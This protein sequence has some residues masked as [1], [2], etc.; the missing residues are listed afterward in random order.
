MSV[1]HPRQRSND[2]D[3]DDLLRKLRITVSS[4]SVMSISIELAY[5]R[6]SSFLFHASSTLSSRFVSRTDIAI[7][8]NIRGERAKWGRI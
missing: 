6:A 4:R 8:R 2:G 7:C 1:H 5:H 3:D